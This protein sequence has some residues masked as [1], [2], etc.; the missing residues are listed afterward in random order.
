MSIQNAMD[1]FESFNI[2]VKYVIRLK[3]T[4]SPFCDNRILNIQIIQCS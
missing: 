4:K 2:V 1:F 3:Y